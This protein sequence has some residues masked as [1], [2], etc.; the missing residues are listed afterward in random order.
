M[1]TTAIRL[2]DASI[3]AL[4]KVLEGVSHEL[5]L[6]D[7]M[8]E[9]DA[10]LAYEIAVVKLTRAASDIVHADTA[11]QRRPAVP[12]DVLAREDRSVSL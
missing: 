11:S 12:A 5:E 3:L 6:L 1:N 8:L 10:V 2:T 9:P 4:A 7:V